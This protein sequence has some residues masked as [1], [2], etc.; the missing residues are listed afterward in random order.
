[1]R[2]AIK[3]IVVGS[4]FSLV[5]TA[6]AQAYIHFLNLAARASYFIHRDP[7]FK[8]VYGSGNFSFESKVSLRVLDG[9][10]IA[11]GVGFLKTKGTI[12]GTDF[13]AEANQRMISAGLEYVFELSYTW[14]LRLGADVLFVNYE[15]SAFGEK[16]ENN[17]LAYR[18]EGGIL[19][20]LSHDIYLEAF[21]AYSFGDDDIDGVSIN[22]GGFQAGIGIAFRL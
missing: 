20:R 8:D 9:L 19:Y 1:M 22:L 12:P 13:D 18:A 3:V 6:N 4:I 11:G 16:I 2:K 10:H 17:G 15:E 5:L 21:T 14:E 7:N